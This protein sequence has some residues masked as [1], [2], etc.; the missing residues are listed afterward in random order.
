MEE[1]ILS[2]LSNTSKRIFLINMGLQVYEAYESPLLE[3]KK[4]K[5]ILNVLDST[6]I[7]HGKPL[8]RSF[9]LEALIAFCKFSTLNKLSINTKRAKNRVPRQKKS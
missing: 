1:A 8:K 4:S 5:R 7:N 2:Y 3:I 9:L 6:N